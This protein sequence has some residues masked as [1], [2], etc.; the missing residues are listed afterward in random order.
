MVVFNCN[1]LYLNIL[2]LQ[3]PVWLALTTTKKQMNASSVLRTI[4]KVRT[5]KHHV[6]LVENSLDLDSAP[7]A[8]MVPP[9]AK[10][11]NSMSLILF[12]G[13]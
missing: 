5:D 3:F 9:H 12:T 4:S 11:S 1:W 6:L 8:A 13:E 2:T 10:V 7:M